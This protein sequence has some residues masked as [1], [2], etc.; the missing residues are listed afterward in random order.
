VI[1]K[2]N[3]FAARAR[4][5]RAAALEIS[6]MLRILELVAGGV[7]AGIIGTASF[8]GVGAQ[9]SAQRHDGQQAPPLAPPG[10]RGSGDP[11][12]EP[13]R[14]GPPGPAPGQRDWRRDGG[15]FRLTP[16]SREHVIAVIADLR[17]LSAEERELLAT[18]SPD[19]LRKKLAEQ[20][21]MILGLARLRETQ[22]E[23]YGLRIQDMQLLR[24]IQDQLQQLRLA[25]DAGQA[26]AVAAA[27]RELRIAVAEQIDLRFAI[28]ER[29][30]T[31]LEERVAVMREELQR[32][33]EQP[34][35]E[36]ITRRLEMFENGDGREGWREGDRRPIPQPG[37][38]GGQ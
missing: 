30:I 8:S 2:W 9:E 20:G 18:M 5:Q 11:S 24:R 19:E 14:Q 15:A 37:D 25:R 21:G 36:L 16:E 33:R 4:C 35:D 17:P 6:N 7:M 13:E 3:Q 22:P 1:A 12:A 23:L 34:R 10:D 38:P 29:E 27:E 31:A 28:R 32:E 26:E